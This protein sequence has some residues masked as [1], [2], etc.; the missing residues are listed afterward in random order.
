[1]VIG[2]SGLAILPR[3]APLWF[4]LM[5]LV[6][7]LFAWLHKRSGAPYPAIASHAAFNFTMGTCIFAALWPM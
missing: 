2:T 4:A 1:L 7:L 3:S 5:V 6:A